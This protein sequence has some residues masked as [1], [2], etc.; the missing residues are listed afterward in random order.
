MLYQVTF[1]LMK[2]FMRAMFGAFGGFRRRGVENVPRRGGVLF[3]P[4]HVCDADPCA[5]AVALPRNAWFM[6]KEELFHIRILGTVVRLWHG[7]PVKRNSADRAALRRAE[8]LLKAGNAVVIFPEGG[9]NEEAILHPLNPGAMLVA[10]R[11]GVPVIPVALVNTNK[12]WPYGETFP[13]RAGVP[14]TVTFGK[15]L[16]LSDLKAKRG[17]VELATA[18]L[19]ETLASMLGQPVPSGKPTVRTEEEEAEDAA[20]RATA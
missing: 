10:L 18:R 2:L 7:F 17:A 15:P 14:V 19:T 1:P 6:A 5:M 9:G 11:A 4:N 16:D 12:V 3:C 13:R 8:E 20:R